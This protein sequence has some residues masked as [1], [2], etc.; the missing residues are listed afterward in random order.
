MT[1]QRSVTTLYDTDQPDDQLGQAF[2]D[3]RVPVAV[4]GLGKMGLPLAAV[5]ADVTG[6]TVGVDIDESVVDAVNDGES[7]VENEPGLA[8]LVDRT[9]GAGR[10]RATTAGES[11]AADASVHVL[12]VPTL[13][14]DDKTPDL[15]TLRAV[16]DDVA[17]G[18]SPGDLVVVESTVPPG[19][20]REV[21]APQA[22]AASGLDPD[23]FG[24]AFCPER[25]MSGRALEDIRGSYPKVVG[26]IDAESTRV[27]ELIYREINDRG[28]IPV[29]DCTTAECV[30]VFEGV[31]RDVNIALANEL[32]QLT[33]SVGVDG[34]E[35]IETA[36]TI[37]QCDIHDPGPGVGGHCI[38]Y[39]PHF[40]IG[41]FETD[42]PLLETARSVNDGMAEYTVS[43]V[44]EELSHLDRGLADATVAVFGVTYRPGVDE[45]RASP[46]IPI[47]AGLTRAGAKVYAVDPV[48]SDFEPFAATP[49]GVEDL[50]DIDPDAVVIVT[51]HDAVGDVPWNA[52][53]ETVVVDGRDV[54]P[55]IP[56]R[57]YTLGRGAR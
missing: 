25:T 23:E 44:R 29:S 3:G 10:L 50:A 16:L 9:V 12:I 38:P 33:D 53:S 18:L 28:V 48:C 57:T 7:P 43:R 41:Q 39:Y 52:L 36:N 30:K 32:A 15:S 34:R 4:Y 20:C 42:T 46:A 54:D 24:V 17:A 47:T 26:G 56:H 45:T 6:N 19:T 49:V 27:A 22:A 11:A 35:A 2:T 1:A 55:E 40:L 37:P 13:V 31:Y 51:G 21:V 5:Y 8:S 14:T